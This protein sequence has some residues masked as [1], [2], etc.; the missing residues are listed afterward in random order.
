MVIIPF[1]IKRYHEAY[2]LWTSIAGMGIRTIDDSEEGIAKFLRRNPASCFL[3]EEAD[4]VIGTILCG[5]DG[6][7]GYIYHICVCP[8]FRGRGIGKKLLE[9]AL[10]TLRDEKI[11]KA[12]LVCFRKN[13]VGN[14]FWKAAGWE[15]RE[16]LNYWNISLN[17]ENK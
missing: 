3:A 15:L 12:T 8:D 2:Q 11:N 17:E 16:D 5:H 4:H 13:E 10:S 14:G 6:R 1:H 9:A 7:R